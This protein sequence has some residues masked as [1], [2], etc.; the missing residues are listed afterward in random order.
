MS[1][2]PSI[3]RALLCG[4]FLIATPAFAQNSVEE[5]ERT[6]KQYLAKNPED[7]Q[8]IVRS[9]LTENPDVLEDVLKE[10]VRRRSGGDGS[11]EAATKAAIKAHS[12][13]LFASPRQIVLGN[14]TGDVTLVEFFDYN[15]G[16]CRRALGDKLALMKDDPRLRIVLKELP[17]LGP[18][19]R[20][21]ASVAVAVGMQEGGGR[22]LAFHRALLE[23]RGRADQARALAVAREV[24]LDMTRLEADLASDEVRKTLDE[25]VRLAR[26]LGIDG[27]P[28]YVVGDAV[29]IG[30]VGFDVLK[31]RIAAARQT[32]S[33]NER[34]VV[35]RRPRR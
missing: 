5:I 9:Y 17:V 22:Y 30:A 2:L 25:S 23:Q 19:S 32:N 28:S 7:V 13:E 26:A 31:E 24:G 21:A 12:A 35:A 20:E 18:G 16:Y 15:C 10:I 34:S 11:A 1:A 4:V 6:I 27:T 8:R 3:A 33:A 14:P 29:V